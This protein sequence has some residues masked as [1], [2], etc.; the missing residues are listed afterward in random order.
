M[1]AIIILSGVIIVGLIVELIFTKQDVKDCKKLFIESHDQNSRII[2]IT[3]RTLNNNE[4]LIDEYK[5]IEE[6]NT[7]LIDE[8]RELA[9]FNIK[10]IMQLENK[11][12]TNNDSKR[13][14]ESSSE[15]CEQTTE[16]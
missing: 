11:E 14:S 6:F 1:I 8:H 10:L 5:K 2:E 3:K 4:I 15:D 13:V 12:E 9:E 7:K 16:C